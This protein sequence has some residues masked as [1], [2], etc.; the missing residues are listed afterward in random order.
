M[1]LKWSKVVISLFC[2]NADFLLVPASNSN[3]RRTVTPM[4]VYHSPLRSITLQPSSQSA[5]RES[6]SQSPFSFIPPTILYLTLS[7]FYPPSL[8]P[9]PGGNEEETW[10]EHN[11]LNGETDF[12]ITSL[13]NPFSP[14][15][16]KRRAGTKRLAAHN[17]YFHLHF[18]RFGDLSPRCSSLSTPATPP[19]LLEPIPTFPNPY[20]NRPRITK[21]YP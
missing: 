17:L 16:M 21:K 9:P 10:H 8:S 20:D 3:T 13:L 6:P 2:N 4:V 7:P 15:P 18:L 12:P 11:S 1:L 5:N 14:Q 19:I